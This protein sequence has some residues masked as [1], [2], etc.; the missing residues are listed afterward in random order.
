MP[1]TSF[2]HKV[3]KILFGKVFYNVHEYMDREWYELGVGHRVVGHSIL[4]LMEIRDKMGIEAF[5]AAV[6]HR[7][8]DRSP[9]IELCCIRGHIEEYRDRKRTKK[10]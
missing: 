6:V 1:H 2:H 5:R 4:D 7:K 3:D 8:L 9:L 10:V